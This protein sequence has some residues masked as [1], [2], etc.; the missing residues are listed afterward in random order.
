MNP[1]L[2]LNHFIYMGNFRKNWSNCTNRTPSP[3]NPRSKHSGSAPAFILVCLGITFLLQNLKS[4]TAHLKCICTWAATPQNQQKECAPSKDSDQPGHLPSL[5]SILA[6]CMK[7]AW[8]LSYPLSAQ[9]RLWS[10]WADAQADLSL[11]WVHSHFVG[12]VMSWLTSCFH[13]FWK[14]GSP[15]HN[16]S[17]LKELFK[18]VTLNI[19]ILSW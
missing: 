7:K 15:S 12:F 18:N 19:L 9:W 13:Y 2:S 10:D 6:V 3:K 17:V 16:F 4:S 8:V 5:I 14:I 11:R 1:L